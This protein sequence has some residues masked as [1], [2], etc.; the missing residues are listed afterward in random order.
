[1]VQKNQAILKTNNM[2][3]PPTPHIVAELARSLIQ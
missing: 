1:M 2:K 3:N